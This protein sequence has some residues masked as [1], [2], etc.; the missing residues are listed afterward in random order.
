MGFVDVGWV[1]DIFVILFEGEIFFKGF[2]RGVGICFRIS[3]MWGEC[4]KFIV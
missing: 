2:V 1:C 4:V 3:C